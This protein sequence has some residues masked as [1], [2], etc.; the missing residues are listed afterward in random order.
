MRATI[1]RVTAQVSMYRLTTIALSAVLAIGLL[2]GSLGVIGVNPY[3]LL[4]T[5]AV[6]VVATLGA[7]EAAARLARVVPHRESSV[8]TALIIA[9]LVPPT[10]AT[11]DLIG[12]AV[13][14]IV[15]A[16]SKYLIVW[17]GRHILNP[18]ATGVL[19]AGLLQLTVGIW[20]IATPAML[21]VV[22]LGALLLLDRTRRLDIGVILV[23][24]TVAIIG[25][26]IAGTGPSALDAYGSVLLL[27]PVVFLAG[28]M[29]SEPLTLPPR[30][31]QQWLV[32]VVTALLFSIPFQFG[33][34]YTSPELALVAANIVGFAVS[35]RGGFSLRLTGSRALSDSATEFTFA[36]SRPVPF[37]P[38]QYLELHLPHRADRRG[39]RRVFSIA[40]APEHDQISLGMRTPT[41]GSSFKRVLREL[42]EGATVQATQISGDFL[43]PRDPAT[44]V[45][46]IAGGIGV[47]PFASQLGSAAARG[48]SR[49]VHVVYVPSRPG[50]VL[51]RD[52][53]ESA[54]ATVTV[55][56]DTPVTADALLT[57]VPDLASRRAYV[58]GAPSLVADAAT[59][60]RRAGARRVR[61][62]YFAGY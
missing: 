23:V 2:L 21:P 56:D 4:A 50:E 39:T 6:V 24:V 45:V 17:R 12:A 7:N 8:I 18:A 25:T 54:G 31:W 32:A 58:S 14:G 20:W 9:C 16:L 33:P 61:T 60:L 41:D 13:A 42:D 59:A 22:A 35:R 62:D 30:R 55:L 10:V 34:L 19:V 44:P 40:S 15:A 46:M 36:P 1:D 49:D 37:E 47:T 29:L 53:L 5:L 43:L 38:G 52:V 11:L 48:E 51:Y 27:F 3:G 57:A 28:Y 26:R